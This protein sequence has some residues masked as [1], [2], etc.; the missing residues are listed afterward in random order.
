MF[1]LQVCIPHKPEKAPLTPGSS[2]GLPHEMAEWTGLDPA[3]SAV[4]GQH[5]NQ[6]NYHSISNDIGQL[7][8]GC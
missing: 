4:T 5:S 2:A 1:I 6:L 3:T 7:A 8:G